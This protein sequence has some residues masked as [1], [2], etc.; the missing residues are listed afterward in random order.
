MIE[1]S[2]NKK[3]S[4]LVSYCHANIIRVHHFLIKPKSIDEDDRRKEHIFTWIILGILL[5]S[6]VGL[7]SEIWQHIFDKALYYEMSFEV[8][9]GV[10]AL[11]IAL[12]VACR[13]GFFKVASYIFLGLFLALAIF[14]S[15]HW[16]V[17]MPMGILCYALLITMT[18]I[19][20]GT[21]AGLVMTAIVVIAIMTIGSREAAQNRIPEWKHFAVGINDLIEYI[22]ILSLTTLIAWLGN[23]EM[24]KSL[25]RAR[26]SEQELIH[27]RDHL[28]ILVEER[29]ESL[30]A[31]ER[32]RMRELYRFAE[33]GK[34]SAG[35][36]HDL[37]NP[38]TAI[39]ITMEQLR[40]KGN[41]VGNDTQQTIANA[42]SATKRMENFLSLIRRQ[43]KS[44]ESYERFS[45]NS[46]ADDVCGILGHHAK[47]HQVKINCH[48][49][50]ELFLYGSPLKFN[51][52]LSNLIA[53]A[54]DSYRPFDHDKNPKDRIVKV[55]IEQQ[56][57]NIIITVRDRGVG[58]NK[59]LAT[60][61]FKPFVTT[62]ENGIGLGLVTLK[63][64]VENHFNGTLTMKS[65]PGNGTVF[66]VTLPQVEHA[67]YES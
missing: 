66:I 48:C 17:S 52:M 55:I 9:F 34:R 7:A 33:F 13:K 60:K 44:E 12:F 42:V 25:D 26:K 1:T 58:I 14:G 62:K 67:S 10:T 37:L 49:Q 19:I 28:E 45:V 54:V 35:L 43:M 3:V 16:G 8:L 18:S 38:L 2:K 21:R 23:H 15:I 57:N 50:P 29:T 24:E 39:S 61:L 59:D 22:V 56:G 65:H 27:Q 41:D 64:I 5:L 20:I 40:M 63:D 36:F 31:L 51:Q 32:E 47:K 53:N 4:S 30:R 46:E 11:F 6:T